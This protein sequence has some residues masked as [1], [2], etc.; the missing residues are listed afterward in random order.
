MCRMMEI[1][2][3]PRG[4]GREMGMEINGKKEASWWERGGT[5]RAPGHGGVQSCR[6]LST[7]EGAEGARGTRK[8]GDDEGK[9]GRT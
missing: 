8:R 2:R 1:D 6:I 4:G 5:P 7:L 3:D 9:K